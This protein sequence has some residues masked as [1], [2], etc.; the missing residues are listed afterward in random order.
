MH[1]KMQKY[2][3]R[4]MKMTENHLIRIRTSI[5]YFSKYQSKIFDEDFIQ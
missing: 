2:D 1:R 3:L 5:F 4:T